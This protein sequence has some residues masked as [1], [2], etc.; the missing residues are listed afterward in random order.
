[1]KIVFMGTPEFAI[2]C[3][4]RLINSND[5][6]IGVFTQP[7]KPKGRGYKLQ[8]PP[9]K[10]LALKNKIEVFQPNSLK[11]SE[12]FN[13]INELSPDLIIVVAYGKIL[14]KEFLKLPKYGCINVHA[15]LLPKYRGA[16][17]IQ[18]SIINGEKTTGVTTMYMSEG[19][20][21]G[22]M[23]KKAEINILQNETAGQLHDKLS[24]M[25]ADLL[26]ETINDLKNNKLK[27]EKQND[28]ESSYA[29][30][31]TQ[32]NSKIN[33]EDN[34]ETVHNFIRGLNPWPV[35]KT[36]LNGKKIKIYSSSI[37]ECYDCL[38]GEI[39]SLSPLIV[40]CNNNTAIIVDE[41]QLEGKKRMSSRDF[42]NG[43]KTE[44][45]SFFG[46]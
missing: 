13:I 18:W 26:L 39:V 43:K 23:L 21:T 4:E 35:A 27:P 40:G 28:N 36:T 42:L 16:A 1:M 41:L 20:D 17:P 25:G 5:E 44:L 30:M 24:K 2:P 10:V 12:S 46:K 3:L 37:L 7:D 6:V 19:L 15:S 11:S 32:E 22:D 29:P 8:Q 31:L 34:A 9:I 45:G 14:P 38:P 33:W